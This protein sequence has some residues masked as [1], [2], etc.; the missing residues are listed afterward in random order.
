M[1]IRPNKRTQCIFNSVI[2][3]LQTSDIYL[4]DCFLTIVHNCCMTHDSAIPV[5]R[6]LDFQAVL[7]PYLDSYEMS[8]NVFILAVATLLD[9]MD[10]EETK[11]FRTKE[12]AVQ[13]FLVVLQVAVASSNR[14]ANGWHP[15]ELARSM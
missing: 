4:L 13:L 5:V 9:I 2:L 12:Y 11:M 15:Y 6:G 8:H 3:M 10:E 7:V 1:V 14:E